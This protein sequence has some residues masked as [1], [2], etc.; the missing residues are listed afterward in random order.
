MKNSIEP[1]NDKKQYD[2]IQVL[3]ITG[4]I[5]IVKIRHKDSLLVRHE[6]LELIGF[7][8][9]LHSSFPFIMQSWHN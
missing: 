7:Q 8:F 2:L 5:W 6:H 9:H 1:L 4:G 3:E